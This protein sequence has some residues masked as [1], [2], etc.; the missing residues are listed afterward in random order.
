MMACRLCVGYR[1]IWQDK[2]FALMYPLMPQM[3]EQGK[4]HHQLVEELHRLSNAEVFDE[5]KAKQIAEKLASLEKDATFKRAQIDSQIF[6]ILTLEQRK[7]LSERKPFQS[8][9][10][11]RSTSQYYVQNIRPEMKDM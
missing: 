11:H 3:R 5:T 4:Q 2:I 1:R 6:A 9:G 10:F 8:V 7:Q